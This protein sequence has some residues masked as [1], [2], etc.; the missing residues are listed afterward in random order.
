M[1]S[2]IKLYSPE[3]QL[4]YIA[5]E[6]YDL[7]NN[8]KSLKIQ[9]RDKICLKSREKYELTI[10]RGDFI[11]VRNS[12]V[13]V[14]SDFIRLPIGHDDELKIQSL[15]S[16]KPFQVKILDHNNNCLAM[17]LF[18]RYKT[19]CRFSRSTNPR[20]WDPSFFP[21]RHKIYEKELAVDNDSEFSITSHIPIEYKLIKDKKR[22]LDE[23]KQ[24]MTDEDRKT[25]WFFFNKKHFKEF[26]KFLIKFTVLYVLFD[27]I[28]LVFSDVF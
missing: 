6:I 27:I 26:L 17:G 3:S 8:I 22:R 9:L 25:S 10:N 7:R 1:N 28:K 15:R 12:F 5:D 13:Y 4:S 20:E 24:T 19:R 11:R 23:Q 18:Y 21:E 14:D 2:V 16:K